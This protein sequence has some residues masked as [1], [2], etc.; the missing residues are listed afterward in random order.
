MLLLFGFGLVCAPAQM[1]K[2]G[3]AAIIVRTDQQVIIAADSKISTEKI[4]ETETTCKIR[5][6]G[7][8]YFVNTGFLGSPINN[9]DV[10][11]IASA[12]CQQAGSLAEKVA[13]FEQMIS[14]S[15]PPVMREIK[16]RLPRFYR[17]HYQDRPIFTITFISIEKNVPI[18]LTRDVSLSDPFKNAA[19]AFVREECPGNCRPDK[20]AML[21]GDVAEMLKYVNR[22]PGILDGYQ[23]IKKLVAAINAVMKIGINARSDSIG[24]PIDILFINSSGAHWLQHKVE[25]QQDIDAPPINK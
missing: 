2:T 23:P 18:Y 13:R 14:I 16:I 10:P 3:S 5:K 1:V 4:G 25:C 24:Y 20:S 22:R 17:Q 12:A 6:V 19:P 11:T 9:F 8:V 21:F 15:L 7:N